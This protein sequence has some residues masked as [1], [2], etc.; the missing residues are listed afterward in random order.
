MHPAFS[1]LTLDTLGTAVSVSFDIEDSES[2]EGEGPVE[3][4]QNG[5]K[6]KIQ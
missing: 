4:L 3:S 5:S 6:S 2:Q 1:H